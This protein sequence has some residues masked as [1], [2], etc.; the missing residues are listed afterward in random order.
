MSLGGGLARSLA[1]KKTMSHVA[2]II[3]VISMYT[4]EY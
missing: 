2:L 4:I 3:T 1:G